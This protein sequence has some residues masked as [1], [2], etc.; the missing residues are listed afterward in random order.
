M[1]FNVHL[2]FSS[3]CFAIATCFGATCSSLIRRYE[4]PVHS[5]T[6]A[7]FPAISIKWWPL[8][9]IIIYLIYFRA[10]NNITLA[11]HNKTVQKS[12][13][14]PTYPVENR[15]AIF[16]IFQK[17]NTEKSIIL[18]FETNIEMKRTSGLGQDLLKLI[19]A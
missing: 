2:I 7:T 1:D 3:R 16:Y 11:H 8:T 18:T 5:C 12:S 17:E 9:F 4:I 13:V 15:I 14:V 6:S 10:K 19:N